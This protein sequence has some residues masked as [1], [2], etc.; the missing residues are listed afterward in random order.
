M[1]Q[2]VLFCCL[3]LALLF[4][5]AALAQQPTTA[6]DIN[7]Y[8]RSCEINRKSLEVRAQRVPAPKIPANDDSTAAGQACEKLQAAVAS[9]NPQQVQSATAT[10]R[11]ILAR[12]GMRPT[13]PQEQLTAW[14]KKTSGA[15]GQE[16]FDWLP[17]LARRAINAGNLAKAENYSQQLLRMAPEYPKS[18][19]Y[20]NAIFYGNFV[21]GRVELQRGNVARAGQYL[22]AAGGTPGSPQLNSFGPDMTLAKGL[23]DKGQSDV[24]L[25]YLALCKNFWKMDRGNLDRWSATIRSGGVPDFRYP[26]SPYGENSGQ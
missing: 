18:W 5:Q 12:M 15:S 19:N 8:L 14:E 2:R 7:S 20:G 21:L 1:I 3:G 23:L 17:E 9:S 24:V 13:T 26:G 4:S 22:L 6:D 10:L 16:L 25:Q 11:P